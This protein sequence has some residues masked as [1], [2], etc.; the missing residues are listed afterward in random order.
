MQ[1]RIPEVTLLEEVGRGPGSVVFRALHR[2]AGC[3]VKLPSEA[4][5]SI[6]AQPSTFEQ[7]MLQLA[8]LSRAGLPRVLQL[9]ATGD[10]PYAILDQARGEPLTALLRRPLTPVTAL[11]LARALTTCLQ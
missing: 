6:A 11:E 5:A 8:R 3:V 7:D 2:G 9:G 1:A 4:V 10:T